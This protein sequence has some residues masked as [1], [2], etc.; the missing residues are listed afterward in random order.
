MTDAN[1]VLLLKALADASRLQILR[2]LTEE[3]ML[4]LTLLY[5]PDLKPG[6]NALQC[7]E[8]IRKLYY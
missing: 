1:T 4:L 2:S 6:M 7:A 3:D 8:V 5:H